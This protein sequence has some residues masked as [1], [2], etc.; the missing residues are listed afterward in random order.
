M[1]SLDKNKI[2]KKISKLEE[3]LKYLE[4]LRSEIKSEDDFINDFRLFG[5]TERYLQLSIQTVLD[6]SHL[7]NTIIGLGRSD[8]NYGAIDILTKKGVMDKEL[9]FKMSQ[10]VGM[11]NILVHGYEEIDKSRIYQAL[12][13][14][15][16]DL[17]SFK[18]AITIFLE[19]INE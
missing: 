17:D 14:N 15:I 19:K 5:N 2:F 9:A 6:I 13:E 3:Y 1:I 4:Q 18:E 12:K 7:V 8:N 10:M 11:R 16:D